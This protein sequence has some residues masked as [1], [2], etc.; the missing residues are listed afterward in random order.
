M[1]RQKAASAD[2]AALQAT[3]PDALAGQRLD[4]V[5]SRLFG[6][7]SRTRLQRWVRDGRVQVDGKVCHDTR[8]RVDGGERLRVEPLL[9]PDP[10]LAPHALELAVVHRDEHLLVLDKPAGLVVH[11]GA[12]NPDRT[13][14]NALVHLDP[15]LA[16]LPRAGL[17]HRLDKNTTGLMVVARSLETQT[18]LARLIAAR[19]VH[20][21]YEAVVHGTPAVSGEVDAP[22]G[23][24]R[25]HRTRMGVR[26]D[27][28]P[29]RTRYRRLAAFRAH[30][31]LALELE[32]GRT[33]QIR[34][35][36]AHLGHPL[37]G[38]REYGGARPPP[39]TLDPAAAQA[40]RRFPRQALH[41]CR[42]AFRHP[43]TGENLTL[44]SRLPEDLATLVA[45]LAADAA[46]GTRE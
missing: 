23:R 43:V 29:S 28:R 2:P 39:A 19:Q 4:Q 35:H 1:T 9:A 46:D 3:V 37:V 18:R 13:L 21:G 25:V 31:H 38:D 12:G 22:I 36:M 8:A 16:T 20:R 17:V 30:S 6:E 41:A 26:S 10:G 7:F 27:G 45:C 32:T 42:L 40:V 34:V 33:H 15:A 11:P 44:E 24:H 14:A 5:L